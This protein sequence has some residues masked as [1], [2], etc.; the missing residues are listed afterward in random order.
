MAAEEAKLAEAVSELSEQLQRLQGAS[1]AASKPFLGP[2]GQ[3]VQWVDATALARHFSKSPKT[4]IDWAEKRIIPG[5]KLPTKK[6]KWL[7]DL[8][9]VDQVIRRY[10]R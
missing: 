8:F 7:F 1:K 5:S 3:L 10:K 2:S 9:E 6:A 4:I